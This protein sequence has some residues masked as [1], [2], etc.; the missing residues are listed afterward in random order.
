[1]QLPRPAA[2]AH[3][4]AGR[5]R[6]PA[7]RPVPRPGSGA[8]V[9]D[10]PRSS[11]ARKS[12]TGSRAAGRRICS[13]SRNGQESPRL[14]D[15]RRAPACLRESLRAPV[16]LRARSAAPS[17]STSK[18][19][20][21]TSTR[22]LPLRRQR[23]VLGDDGPA[24]AEQLHVTP[25]GIDHR[26]DREGHA[27]LELEPGARL[28]VVQYLRVL[29]EDAA[30]AVAAVLTH[31]RIALG[32]DILLDGMCPRSPSRRPGATCRMPRHMASKPMLHSRRAW[33]EQSPTWN[34]RL[35]SPWK[36]SLMTV[37]STIDDV[38]GPQ[39]PVPGNAMADDV[40]DRGADRL[41][42]SLV[43]QGCGDGLLHLDDIVVANPVDFA[44][45]DAGHDARCRSCPGRR[46]PGG[47]RRASPAAR[48]A[49]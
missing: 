41:R 44:G 47:R 19:S 18:P 7:S 32:L 29:V 37:M 40:V 4:R 28:A 35:V 48:Q 23:V 46:R 33:T 3:R 13:V 27:R 2:P 16:R 36:P 22:V 34:M 31:D 17:V 20:A 9:R 45:G 11:A 14:C 24:I 43:I 21:V 25:A 10:R 38:A 39:L 49:T 1:M 26:L 12:R 5:D 30:D 42:K 8:R 6:A 15:G